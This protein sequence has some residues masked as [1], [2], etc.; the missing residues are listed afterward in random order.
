MKDDDVKI[1][2]KK[3]V[4]PVGLGLEKYLKAYQRESKLPISYFDLLDFHETIP[5]LDKNGEDTLWEVPLYPP[6]LQDQI[7]D[8]L[9]IVYAKLKASGNTR[10][11]QHKTIDKIEFC[12]FG[13]SHPFRVK[14]I[15]RLNDVYD[16]F[17]I[18]RADASRIYGLELEEIMSPNQVNYL[19]DRDTLVEEHIVGIPGDVFAQHHMDTPEYNQTRIA[20]E[21]VKF[22][23]RCVISVLGDMR[24][25]NFVMQ[26]TPDFDDFQFRIRAIDFDQQ[27]YEGNIKVYLPQFFKENLRY[28]KLS[29]DLLSE[30]TVSQYQQ[31]ERSS[32]VHRVRSERHRIRDLRDASS[33]QQLSTQKNIEQLREGYANFYNNKHYYRCQSMTD[34]IELNVKNVIRQ[35]QF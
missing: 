14:I 10:I 28:V 7:Y 3:P 33:L 6:H 15:N 17:Y 31:E 30:R 32:I 23:E 8:H 2:R 29:M 12:S 4:F 16:Y 5:S 13:N 20:K 25:Y 22:N 35:V 21:F 26:I 27:F 18:K 9:K 11:V 24:A 34:I 1:S 19:V